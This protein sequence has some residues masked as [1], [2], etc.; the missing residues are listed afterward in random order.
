MLSRRKLLVKSGL[1]IAAVVVGGATTFVSGS[2]VET[3]KFSITEPSLT[4]ICTCWYWSQEDLEHRVV[5]MPMEV[6]GVSI[7]G[8]VHRLLM[9][10]PNAVNVFIRL[11]DGAHITGGKCF[12]FSRVDSTVWIGRV[13]DADGNWTKFSE[14]SF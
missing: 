2:S 11:V 1:G 14:M 9:K 5:R 3:A 10:F 13:F 4:G 7:E 12:Y 6:Q 8:M